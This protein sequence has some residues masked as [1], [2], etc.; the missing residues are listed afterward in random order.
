MN[1]E[2]A[3]VSFRIV[4]GVVDFK[5]VLIGYYSQANLHPELEKSMNSF[6]SS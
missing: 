3:I 1:G 6:S 4:T 5:S 2:I